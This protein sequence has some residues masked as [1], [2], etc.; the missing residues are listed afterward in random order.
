MEEKEKK[1]NLKILKT[2]KIAKESLGS[3]LF[4]SHD[5]ISSKKSYGKGYPYHFN[6]ITSLSGNT[7]N[8]PLC[9]VNLKKSMYIYIYI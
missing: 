6:C 4:F 2:L 9:F 1:C 5:L 8:L 7:N 3:E